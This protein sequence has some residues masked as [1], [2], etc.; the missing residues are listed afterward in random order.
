MQQIGK[1]HS[2]DLF[3]QAGRSLVLVLRSVVARSVL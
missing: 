1:V 3:L 2:N